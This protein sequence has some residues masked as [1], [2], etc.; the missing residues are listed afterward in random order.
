MS[1]PLVFRF[2]PE[3]PDVNSDPSRRKDK[4]NLP[5][6]LSDK[7]TEKV[8]DPWLEL[9]TEYQEKVEVSVVSVLVLRTGR[10]SKCSCEYFIIQVILLG[11]KKGVKF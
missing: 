10:E 1:R 7:R 9:G 5:D 4:E 8:K 6:S 11:L 2:Y 3:W